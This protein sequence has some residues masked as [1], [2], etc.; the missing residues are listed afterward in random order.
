MNLMDN[1]KR[2]IRPIEDD[3]FE[4]YPV[5]VKPAASIWDAKPD[6]LTP[7]TQGSKVVNIHAAAQLQ[8]V[9]VKSER[10]ES[11]KEIADHLRAKRAVVLNLESTNKEA[12]RRILDFVSGV[13]YAQDG[14]IRKVAVSTYMITP[15]SV[16]LPDNLVDELENKGLHI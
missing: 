10:Y 15:C 9:L 7:G 13:A 14:K 4:E 12:T 16:E 8:V 2:V 5:P 6:P 11:A 3:D 1:L